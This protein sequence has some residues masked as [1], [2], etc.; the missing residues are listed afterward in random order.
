MLFN[1]TGYLLVFLPL[2]VLVFVWLQHRGASNLQ[3]IWLISASLVFYGSWN[4]AF[5]LLILLSISLNFLV[6]HRLAS[7]AAKRRWLTL[8]VGGNLAVLGYFKYAN[9]FVDNLNSLGNWLIPLPS[10]TLP[11]AISFFTFQQIA[12]LVDV[13]RDQCRDYEFRHYALFVLFFPQLVAGPIVHH[14]EMMPQFQKLGSTASIRT[15]LTVGLTFIIIGLFKKLV[16]A[17]SLALYADPI[18]AAAHD[19]QAIAFV[20]SWIAS[21]AF[22]F[23]IYFDFS[24]YSDLAIGS[25]RLFGIRLPENFHSPYQATSVIEFWRRW[26][27]TL[28][29]FL[30]NYLYIPLGGNR[31]G[32]WRRYRNLMLTMLLGGLWHG[33]AW[34]FVLWG[35]LHGVYLCVNHAW[36]ALTR[37]T[38]TGLAGDGW[39]RLPGLVLTFV[40]VALAFTVFRATDFASAASILSAGFSSAALDAPLSLGGAI[41]GTS[42]GQVLYA[43]GFSQGSYLAPALVLV[44]AGSVCW[45]LP[46][47]QGFLFQFEPVLTSLAADDRRPAPRLQWHG[48]ATQALVLGFLLGC[49][50]L[51]LWSVTEFI[52]FQF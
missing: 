18:H 40:A 33:A 20:D 17:D 35:A 13:S 16:L 50:L 21:F 8:G 29:R 41:R 31:Y 10:I 25:A 37:S 3:T 39:L 46:N 48:G 7:S 47:T 32:K 24:G 42:L 23:Q 34:N 15:D 43:L 51:S 6:G 5:V 9:F 12:Y 14:R 30:R 4:A 1:S 45:L 11:L 44:C 27:M 22:S 38:G 49:S 2:V 19:G 28:S 36:R 52:Y 26:H